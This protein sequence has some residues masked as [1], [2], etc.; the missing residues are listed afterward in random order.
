MLVCRWIQGQVESP[1]GPE[2]V[3]SNYTVPLLLNIC[4]WVYAMPTHLLSPADSNNIEVSSKLLDVLLTSMLP[5]GDREATPISLWALNTLAMHAKI[6]LMEMIKVH[7][8]KVVK[9]FK[10]VPPP[11]DTPTI[12]AALLETYSRLLVWLGTRNFQGKSVTQSPLTL[13]PLSL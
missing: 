8:I 9:A 4:E 7:L 6:R 12:S 5:S 3:S 10:Q 1:P 11:T 13:T 2:L